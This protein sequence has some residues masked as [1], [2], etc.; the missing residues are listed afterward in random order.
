MFRAGHHLSTLVSVNVY[1]NNLKS[2][3]FLNPIVLHHIRSKLRLQMRSI[4]HRVYAS[5]SVFK[6]YFQ[7]AGK[8]QLPREVNAGVPYWKPIARPGYGDLLTEAG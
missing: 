8:R 5:K 3:G 1:T 6:N 4:S 7:P 2:Y